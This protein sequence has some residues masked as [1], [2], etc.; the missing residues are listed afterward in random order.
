[1]IHV[2]AGR[3]AEE[4]SDLAADA[5]VEIAGWIE[6]LDESR[7]S[8]AHDPPILWVDRQAAF[9][10]H[11]PIVPAIGAVRR[12]ALIERLVAEGRRLVTLVHPSAVI[13]RSAV[14]EAGCVVFPNVVVGAQSVIGTG[15]IL[16]R[17][18]LVGHHATIGRHSFLGP[19]AVVGGGVHTGEQVYLGMASV[20][21]DD[22]RVGDR[23]ILGAGAV[24][25][26]D[27][28]PDTTAVGVPAR[29]LT[30]EDPGGR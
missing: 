14:L 4:I 12:R 20:V 24:A 3:F 26:A 1:V 13:A 18:V 7:A 30:A 5:G 22:R 17:G 10:P 21:R 23:A 8:L 2:G 6:G 25:V 27:V 9:E 16:N 19:G 15:T 29:P 11:L 28:A